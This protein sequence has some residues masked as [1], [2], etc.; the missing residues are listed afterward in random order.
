MG[1]VNEK[2]EA[3]Q[4]YEK[5]INA[6]KV[7]SVLE[8]ITPEVFQASIGNVPPNTSVT[9]ILS[10]ITELGQDAEDNQIR[11]VLPTA[12]IPR[13]G[14]DPFDY[15]P[16]QVEV[17]KD[18]KLQIDVIA[19]MSSGAI[20]SMSS[21]TH[22][23]SVNL[24]PHSENITPASIDLK[25]TF[26]S[27]IGENGFSKLGVT[28]SQNS[29][30]LDKDFVLV[31]KA[32]NLDHP[33]CLIEPSI[34]N[35]PNTPE[36]HAMLLTLTPRFAT[37]QIRTELLFIVD[38]SGS[39]W[40]EKINQS[41][42]ALI[43][44]LKSIPVGCYFNVIGFGD[45]FQGIWSESVEYSQDNV[46]KALDYAGTLDADMGGT[47][48]L[49]PLTYAFENRR[50]DMPT[51]ILLLTDGE[52]WNVDSVMKVVQDNMANS[53]PA[54]FVRV[55]T[56]GIGGDVSH[57]LVNSL[58]RA[59]KGYSSFVTESERMEKKVIRMLKNAI[60]PP[61]V[62]YRISWPNV[63]TISKS[64]VVVESKDA[65]VIN[66]FDPSSS[67][68]V[69]IE[70]LAFQSESPNIIQSPHYVP[71]IYT[72]SRLLVYAL[73]RGKI[74]SLPSKISID[75]MC[76]VDPVTL[77]VP[78][79]V[80]QPGN[81]IHTLAARSIIRDLEEGTSYLHDNTSALNRNYE[82]PAPEVLVKETVVDFGK[83][84]SLA[85]KYTSFIAVEADGQINAINEFPHN[86]NEYSYDVDECEYSDDD[87]G[88]GLFDGGSPPKYAA[89]LMASLANTASP[90]LKA[91]KLTK[92][93]TVTAYASVESTFVCEEEVECFMDLRS[94]TYLEEVNDFERLIKAQDFE[95][96][97]PFSAL[98]ID[99]LMEEKIV[100][101]IGSEYS[102]FDLEKVWGTVVAIAL[103]SKRFTDQ[104]E[105]WELLVE[106][107]KLYLMGVLRMDDAALSSFIGKW[108]SELGEIFEQ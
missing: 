98:S 10:Y 96:C 51:Q 41:K 34:S 2:E 104:K 23:I 30:H 73:L 92:T 39:M 28:L 86:V 44:F 95:G 55:F 108:I 59:G 12:I 106:K 99:N 102:T 47:E 93:V 71:G 97:F 89:P 27:G 64:S 40:G 33:T 21:P 67:S 65:N 24:D 17:S 80:C 107:S 7:A 74:K 22:T 81:A 49:N 62:D 45:T 69:V 105:E 100:E 63:E 4:S 42:K 37:K 61:I 1:V 58:S 38:R 32:A 101:K 20:Q 79:S 13:Y 9:I 35:D 103:L 52:V 8:N 76:G 85:S 72:G 5:A 48:I 14:E 3:R 18:S 91:K 54:S 78:I 57:H 50:K 70:P 19:E 66:L 6:G 60:L 11:F 26:A 88:F 25:S 68:E 16:N 36:T 53:P 90:T 87:M 46:N 83:K 31:I 75:G 84:Y 29:A 82:G 94:S 77:T 56:L 43:L 15:F